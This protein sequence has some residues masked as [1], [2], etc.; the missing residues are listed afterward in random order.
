[1]DD[2]LPDELRLQL[3]MHIGMRYGAVPE[4]LINTRR[5]PTNRISISVD[6]HMQGAV[7][8]IFSPTHPTL[9]L[10]ANDSPAMLATASYHSP[11]FLTQD[12]V[13]CVKAEGL[14][15]PRCFAQRASDGSVA[16]QLSIVPKLNL[17]HITAQEYIFLVDRS[18]SMD[19]PRMSTVRKALVMLLRALPA[20]GTRFNV[21]SFGSQCDSYWPKSAAYGQSTLTAAVRLYYGYCEISDNKIC[22]TD[23]ACGQHDRQL[24]R[25]GDQ[26]CAKCSV[27]VPKDRHTHRC[28]LAHRRR[29]ERVL[30]PNRNHVS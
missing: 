28:V 15:A 19:G 1:M 6:V 25:D 4:A 7:K 17:P 12:F 5:V 22:S 11:H 14:D 2:N 27:C 23:G 9:I 13:L 21:F 3:P 20:Q 30:Y 24:W 10:D 18:G 8:S 26:A 29:G 16:M